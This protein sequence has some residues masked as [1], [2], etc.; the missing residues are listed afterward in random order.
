MRPLI[1]LFLSIFLALGCSP[2]TGTGTTTGPGPPV[3]G[4]IG[5]QGGGSSV[6]SS[7]C[8]YLDRCPN[9]FFAFQAANQ[10]ECIQALDFLLTCRIDM[11]PDAWGV[12]QWTV[13]QVPVTVDSSQF[14]ACAAWLN[15]SSCNAWEDVNDGPCGVLGGSFNEDDG[16]N[17]PQPQLPG[18][19]ESCEN[20]Y[21]CQ[22]GLHCIDFNDSVGY[23]TRE[24]TDLCRVCV[25]PSGLGEDCSVVYCQWDETA[26]TICDPVEF[27]CVTAPSAGP[28]VS[29]ACATDYYCVADT[30]AG[31]DMC[32]R[33]GVQGQECAESALWCD[34][35]LHCSRGLGTCEL[36]EADGASCQQH[37]SCVSGFCNRDLLDTSDIK[38]VCDSGGHE[39]FACATNNGCRG[40][41]CESSLL[42]CIDRRA[43]GDPCYKDYQCLTGHCDTARNVCGG[44]GGGAAC[45]SDVDCSNGPCDTN[46]FLCGKPDGGSCSNDSDCQSGAC[47]SGSCVTRAELGGSCNSDDQCFSDRCWGS[48]CR[49][50]CYDTDECAAGEWCDWDAR[51]CL[52]LAEDGTNCRDDESCK[53]G[54]CSSSDQCG[55][56]PDIGDACSNEDCYPWGQ[57]KGGICVAQPGPGEVCEGYDACLAPYACIDGTCTRMG[58]Q[59]RAAS[60]GERCTFFVACE[61]SLWCD[62]LQSFRCAQRAPTGGSCILDWACVQGNECDGGKCVPVPLL[63]ADFEPCEYSQECVND[64]CDDGICQPPGGVQCVMPQ[65]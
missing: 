43:D 35:G 13:T 23:P 58:L 55:T 33:R 5:S 31:T 19:G 49:V 1:V 15:A 39:G 18:E 20:T 29:S 27:V 41:N 21:S 59:C 45:Q 40:N 65:Q 51:A 25:S 7:L 60:L 6:L 42:V 4:G 24:E 2:S 63:K 34:E 52:P 48:I 61:D 9:D 38:G 44:Q 56:K 14:A 47:P 53:N 8:S 64:Y 17:Q 46:T 57:C 10:A 30:E 62:P 3:T 28:C 50:A 26:E 36:P 11:E 22:E 54:W 37:A 32:V 16:D 12:D